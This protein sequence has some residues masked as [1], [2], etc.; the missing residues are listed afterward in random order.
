VRLGEI[1]RGRG[2]KSRAKGKGEAEAVR[3]SGK[4]QQTA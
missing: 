2:T 1:E 3:Y 4:L